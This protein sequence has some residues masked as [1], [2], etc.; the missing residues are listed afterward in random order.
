[1]SKA[2]PM[3]VKNV[4]WNDARP[5]AIGGAPMMKTD[6][7]SMDVTCNCG[8]SWTATKSHI[9]GQPAGFYEFIGG[10]GVVCPSC[11]RQDQFSDTEAS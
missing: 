11:G 6:R 3:S 9:P 5:N 2:G 10:V 4:I 8:H 1:M 7:K